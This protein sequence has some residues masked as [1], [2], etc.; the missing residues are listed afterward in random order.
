MQV[1]NLS[2]D[3]EGW[4]E[5][6]VHAR[7][8]WVIVG[9]GWCVESTSRCVLMACSQLALRLLTARW[10]L[11]GLIL[12][13]RLDRLPSNKN[14]PFLLMG[15]HLS[16]IRTVLFDQS[17]RCMRGCHPDRLAWLASS[18]FL[19]PRICLDELPLHGVTIDESQSRVH[20][21]V[22]SLHVCIYKHSFARCLNTKPSMLSIDFD[23]GGRKLDIT[24]CI[25]S[26]IIITAVD[27]TRWGG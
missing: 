26:S 25:D 9:E 18:Q 11:D 6:F 3:S 10:Q 5:K 17:A 8:L 12:L 22:V 4:L 15:L 20:I 2:N 21:S 24:L 19:F 16:W 1:D 13:G 23:S 14:F 7:G 27:A